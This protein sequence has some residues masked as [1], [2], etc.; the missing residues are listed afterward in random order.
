L[1]KWFHIF[2]VFFRL[3]LWFRRLRTTLFVLISRLC[4]V[5]FLFPV[6]VRCLFD[7]GWKISFEQVHIRSMTMTSASSTLQIRRHEYSGD[8]NIVILV[9]F[10]GIDTSMF[11]AINMDA[12]S[13]FTDSSFLFLANMDLYCID[14]LYQFEWMNI[15][16]F[17]QKKTP[18][19]KLKFFF[20]KNLKIKV[21]NHIYSFYG[22]YYFLNV[23]VKIWTPMLKLKLN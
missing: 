12:V 18:M 9:K 6:L 4:A 21:K 5:C 11:Y 3:F 17:C 10:V 22:N 7:S 14:V 15:V 23:I 20:Y 8:L 13:L 16:Y 2:S 1:N 19:L